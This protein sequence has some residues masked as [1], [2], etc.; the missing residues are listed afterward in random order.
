MR[1]LAQHCHLPLKQ[2]LQFLIFDELAATDHLDCNWF[3]RDLG[4]SSVDFA[5]LALA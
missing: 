5:E 4:E 1:K 3:S 2:L